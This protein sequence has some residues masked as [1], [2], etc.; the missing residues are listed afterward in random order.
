MYVCTN[1][2]EWFALFLLSI[3]KT[4]CL[5]IGP[6]IFPCSPQGSVEVRSL[7]KMKKKKNTPPRCHEKVFE[8]YKIVQITTKSN[9]V[10]ILGSY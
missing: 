1:L 5:Q 8:G 3:M 9:S 4:K 7:K 6:G 10:R 2:P